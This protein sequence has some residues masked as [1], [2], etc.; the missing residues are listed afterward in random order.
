MDFPDAATGMPNQSRVN[1]ESN[2]TPCDPDDPDGIHFWECDGIADWDGDL[3]ITTLMT[4]GLGCIQESMTQWDLIRTIH[5][6]P[7]HGNTL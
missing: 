3:I 1:P 4:I 2:W 6:S 7:L 5:E